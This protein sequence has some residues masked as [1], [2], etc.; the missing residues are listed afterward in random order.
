MNAVKS[1]TRYPEIIIL[2]IVLKKNFFPDF[3]EELFLVLV[4][5]DPE[6]KITITRVN[7]ISSGYLSARDCL[8]K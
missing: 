2:V 6:M 5:G 3:K 1:I 4:R 8:I 7:A